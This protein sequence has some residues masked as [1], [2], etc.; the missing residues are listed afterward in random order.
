M[1]VK[2]ITQKRKLGKKTRK[3][4]K[5]GSNKYNNNQYNKTIELSKNQIALAENYINNFNTI[6]TINNTNYRGLEDI[7]PALEYLEEK[8][9]KPG[10]FE[11]GSYAQKLALTQ[12]ALNHAIQRVAKGR[13]DKK[14]LLLLQGY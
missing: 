2:R 1:A 4:M 12:K 5:G 14:N 7:I 8:Y 11:Q 9:K 6:K 3:S 10:F 13:E